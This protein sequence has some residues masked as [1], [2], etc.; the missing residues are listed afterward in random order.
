L[1]QHHPPSTKHNPLHRDRQ[2]IA[3]PT[4]A[5][6]PQCTHTTNIVTINPELYIGKPFILRLFMATAKNVVNEHISK[7]RL[8]REPGFSNRLQP[9]SR[10]ADKNRSADKVYRLIG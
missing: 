5:N 1:S 4:P 3:F 7:V 9:I 10:S 2:S 8:R 6:K